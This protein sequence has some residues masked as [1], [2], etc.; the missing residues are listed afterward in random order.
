MFTMSLIGCICHDAQQGS[1]PNL[2]GWSAVL[3][4]LGYENLQF[5]EINCSDIYKTDNVIT[6]LEFYPE[7]II[8]SPSQLTYKRKYPSLIREPA[9]HQFAPNLSKSRRFCEAGLH[10]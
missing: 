4:S 6:A 1:P 2:D 5:C 3:L 7:L 9:H 10:L 8:G